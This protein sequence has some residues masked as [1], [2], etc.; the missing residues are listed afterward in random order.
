MSGRANQTHQLVFETVGIQRVTVPPNVTMC[1]RVPILF[2]FKADMLYLE[3][4]GLSLMYLEGPD[5]VRTLRGPIP[6]N[7]YT[8]RNLNHKGET[9][10]YRNGRRGRPISV[11]AADMGDGYQ[12]LIDNPTTRD[13]E[14]CGCLEGRRIL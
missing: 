6:V 2:L 3:G 5:G 7:Y 10:Q 9:D 12:L 1:L 14:L 13:I 8:E 11:K 4:P